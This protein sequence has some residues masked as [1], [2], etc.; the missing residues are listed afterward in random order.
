[1]HGNTAKITL[2][3]LEFLDHMRLLGARW[4]VLL[5]FAISLPQFTTLTVEDGAGEAMPSLTTLELNEDPPAIALVVNVCQQ[6]QCLAMRPSSA[7]ARSSVE[8]RLPLWMVRMHSEALSAP[9]LSEPATRS[10]S[11]QSV[12]HR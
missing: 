1:M 4:Q 7:M 12:F 9:S 8:V 5:A 11:S 2:N 6:K 10:M 3:T